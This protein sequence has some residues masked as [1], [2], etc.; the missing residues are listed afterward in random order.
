MRG[1][2][3]LSILLAGAVRLESRP[4]PSGAVS[5]RILRAMGRAPRLPAASASASAQMCLRSVVLRGGGDDDSLMSVEDALA[6]GDDEESS[7]PVVAM[8]CHDAENDGADVALDGENERVKGTA[9]GGESA[10]AP[11]RGKAE[12]GARTWIYT[13]ERVHRT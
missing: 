9:R 8:G 13:R 11:S 3:G 7:S 10:R 1:I 2:L 6:S 5:G 4:I 12:E